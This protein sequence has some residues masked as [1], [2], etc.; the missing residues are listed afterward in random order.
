MQELYDRMW[1]YLYHDMPD[2]YRDELW[3]SMLAEH[4]AEVVHKMYE[5]MPALI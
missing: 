3:W 2:E 5:S 1:S 4:G